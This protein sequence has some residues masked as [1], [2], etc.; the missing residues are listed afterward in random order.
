MR[1]GQS[2]RKAKSFIFQTCNHFIIF[3]KNITFLSPWPGGS[4]SHLLPYGGLSG[5]TSGGGGG[6]Q[7]KLAQSQQHQ[8]GGLLLDPN[9]HKLFLNI[10]LSFWQKHNFIGMLQNIFGAFFMNNNTPIGLIYLWKVRGNVVR[11]DFFV[12]V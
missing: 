6:A 4:G 3:S 10:L 5:Y 11:F 1:E 12:P 2:Y 7:A 8:R 9:R